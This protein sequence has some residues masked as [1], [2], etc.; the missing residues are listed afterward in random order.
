MFVRVEYFGFYPLGADVC[1]DGVKILQAPWEKCRFPVFIFGK[2][3]AAD[4]AFGQVFYARND[5]RTVFFVAVE[6]GLGHYHI[7]SLSDRAQKKMSR[8]LKNNR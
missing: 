7:F 3:Q 6:Y 1:F 5:G 4:P 8:K 2:K